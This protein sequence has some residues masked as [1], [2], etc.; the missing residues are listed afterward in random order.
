M[1]MERLL[2]V[3]ASGFLGSNVA[4]GARQQYSV[5]A[6]SSRSKVR[7]VGMQAVVSDL[8]EI[9]SA[10][11]LVRDTKPDLVINCSALADP[12][13]CET[14]PDRAERLNAEVP[15]ELARQCSE[16]GADLI[17]ISTD[18]VFGVGDGP[19][20][21]E[22]TPQPVNIYGATKLDGEQRVR[23]VLPT[24]LIVRTNIVGWSPTGQRSLLEYFYSRLVQGQAAPGFVDAWFRP[25]SAYQLWPLLMKLRSDRVEGIWHATGSTHLSKFQFGTS[26]AEIFGLD[27]SLVLPSSIHS[28][29]LSATRPLALDVAPSSRSNGVSYDVLSIESGLIDLRVLMEDGY[30][31]ELESFI[32]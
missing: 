3:G 31:S 7:A 14:Y 11:R 8:T 24:A 15:E 1:K 4:I 32:G 18:A 29:T 23:D 21:P 5:V 28:S 26:I 30:R 9:G 16:I 19:F 17:H 12:D 27:P 10:R 2:I 22:D 20:N 13:L 6:H 25:V